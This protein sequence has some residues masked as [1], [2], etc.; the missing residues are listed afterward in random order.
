M[1]KFFIY[2]ASS[3]IA[4][5]ASAESIVCTPGKLAELVSDNTTTT[6]QISGALNASDFKFIADNLTQLQSLDISDCTIEAYTSDKPLFGNARSFKADE[7]PTASF[8][9]SK[10]SS[11]NLPS[12]LKSIGEGAFMCSNLETITLPESLDSIAAYSFSACSQLSEITLPASVITVCEGAFSHCP[13][14]SKVT[15]SDQGRTSNIT[16]GNQAFIDCESLAEVNLGKWTQSIGNKAFSGCSSPDFNIIIEPESQLCEIGE[17]AFMGSG[18]SSFNFENCPKLTA[19]PA[20]SFAT[21]SLKSVA[22]PS[23]VQFVGE[24]TFFYG[25]AITSINLAECSTSISDLMFA[26]CK[27]STSTGLDDTTTEIG[28]YAYYGWDQTQKLILPESVAFVGDNAFANMKSLSKITSTNPSAPELGN[29]VFSG[30]NP[31]EVLLT[32]RPG[33]TGYTTAEQWKDFIMTLNG[34]ADNNKRININDITTIISHILGNTPSD[35]LFEAADA[36]VDE[37][38]ND[39]DIDD[40]ITIISNTSLKQ[41][42]Q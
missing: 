20:Y 36:N 17:G 23:N 12:S 39:S 7:I 33:S 11:I 30:I 6:L 35:F 34:D 15:I 31:T 18:I 25:T 32:T 40:V 14:L 41:E 16:I 29:D 37:T 28:K 27:N 19:I 5:S 3:L 10:I 1:H 42:Q 26:G 22:L 24:G 13:L 4:F 38:V 2:I 9:D 21:S 8:A